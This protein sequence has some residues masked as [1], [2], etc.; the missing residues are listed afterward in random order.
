MTVWDLDSPLA[1]GDETA[2]NRGERLQDCSRVEG[3]K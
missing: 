3:R 1:T 2:L